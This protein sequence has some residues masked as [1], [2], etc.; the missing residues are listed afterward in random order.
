MAIFVTKKS[1]VSKH[2]AKQWESNDTLLNYLEVVGLAVKQ[3]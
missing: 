3:H 1:G 2:F